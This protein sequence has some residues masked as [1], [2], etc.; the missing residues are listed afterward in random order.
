MNKKDYEEVLSAITKKI[1]NRDEL[2]KEKSEELV[3][4][5]FSKDFLMQLPKDGNV[6]LAMGMNSGGGN[7]IIDFKKKT[8]D[9]IFFLSNDLNK[10]EKDD[11]KL[12]NGIYIFTKNYHKANYEIF[13]SIDAKAHWAMDGY[14][15]DE[16]I[17][18]MILN[19]KTRNQNVKYD[20]NRII[21][22]IRKMQRI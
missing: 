6:V 17:E 15:P 7:E 13:D 12:F 19:S 4:N 9:S 11:L 22:I 20:K 8:K 14:L 1:L 10:D 16:E 5:N 21:Q 3:T 2:L 18:K